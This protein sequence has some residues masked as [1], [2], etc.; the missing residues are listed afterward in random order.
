VNNKSTATDTVF[1]QLN[2]H[3]SAHNVT[4]M[5]SLWKHRNLKLWQN[6]IETS[7]QIVDRALQPTVGWIQAKNGIPRQAKCRWFLFSRVYIIKF[8]SF[9]FIR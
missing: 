1:L 5:W 9:I 2:A 7:A 8:Y 3:E 4:I 6:G